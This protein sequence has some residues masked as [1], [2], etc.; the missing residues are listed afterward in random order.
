MNKE[1]HND[2]HIIIGLDI[3]QSDKPRNILF[4]VQIIRV[5]RVIFVNLVDLFFGI[6]RLENV[7]YILDH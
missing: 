2:I 1:L 6:E 4:V 3:I 5:T 7:L